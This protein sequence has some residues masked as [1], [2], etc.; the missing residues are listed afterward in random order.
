MTPSRDAPRPRPRTSV[1]IPVKD[2]AGHLAPCL[3]LLAR[4]TLPVDEVIVVDN[5]SVD[6]SGDVA[7]RAGARVV[8]CDV[9]GIPATAARGYDAATGDVILR[10]DADCRPDDGWA[11]RMV[12]AL[13]RDR[14]VAAVSSGATFVDGPRALRRPLAALYLG[15]YVLVTSATLGHP[16]VFGSS[17]AMRRDAWQAVR[18]HVHRDDPEIHDDLDLA[19]HLGERHR[20]RWIR[21]RGMGMSMRPFAV[22]AGFSRRIVRGV[23]TVAVHWP[24][25]FPPFRWAALGMLA[26]E[27]TTRPVPAPSTGRSGS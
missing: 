24:R 15:A 11:R 17:L 27:R 6:G 12:D 2:D 22:G 18:A 5:A 26:L 13:D 1:V 10:L 14:R 21:D 3:E 25:D 7:R 16:P 23:R 4:Q 8:R 19:F 20:V 9:D